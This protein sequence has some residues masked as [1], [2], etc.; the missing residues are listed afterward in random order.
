L[1]SKSFKRS[2]A[3]CRWRQFTGLT[4]TNCILSC[5]FD[6]TFSQPCVRKKEGEH[7]SGL[8]G[9][10]VKVGWQ[11]NQCM[12]VS[13]GVSHVMRSCWGGAGMDADVLFD[14]GGEYRHV[15]Y[16]VR[17]MVINKS[18]SDKSRGNRLI[19]A[20]LKSALKG[21]SSSTISCGTGFLFIEFRCDPSSSCRTSEPSSS[22][23]SPS[24]LV[25]IFW[26]C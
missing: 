3:Y 5:E 20:T 23:P 15:S 10:L 9:R 13:G 4:S 21:Y 2:L 19:H 22:L 12:A 11:A 18:Y 7:S 14:V 17:H 6:S 8:G 16:L 1:P 24:W 25:R 26:W